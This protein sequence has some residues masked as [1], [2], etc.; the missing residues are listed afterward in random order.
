MKKK[1]LAIISLALVMCVMLCACGSD[2]TGNS[3]ATTP[4][5]S[6]AP[7]A[8]SAPAASTAPSASSSGMTMGTGGRAGT[9]YAFGNVLSG[10]MSS[11]SG[12]SVNVVSTDGSAADIYGI[13]D[14]LYQLATVQS[15]VMAYAW[16]GSKSFSADG[17]IDSFRVI[18]GLYE[19]A[20]QIV[21]MDENIKTV[22]DLEGKTVSIGAPSS[23]VYFNAI[24][25]LEAYGLSE[26]S[27]KPEYLSFGESTDAMKDGKIDAAFI[28]A[29]P[30]TN[31]ITELATTNGVYL[32]NIEDDIADKLIESCPY[33]NKYVISADTYGLDEDVHT[34]SVKATMIVSADASEEDVYNL[35]AG[36]FDNVDAIT[37]QHAKGSELSIENATTG[38]A[39]P[40]HAGA[41]KYFA[42]KGITVDAG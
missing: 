40:F 16:E 3:A 22:A 9:Y 33:Y 4:A 6:D 35:T 18:G 12:V 36:I 20:V 27:I 13:D 15:D 8:R 38:M 26:D 37:A 34:V 31:A 29:G 1:I 24:D 25:V 10:F 41:A 42:E 2:G 39:V 23:G 11:A 17:K 21:T 30:P 7:A 14:G 32:V 28:V 19:E 5:P